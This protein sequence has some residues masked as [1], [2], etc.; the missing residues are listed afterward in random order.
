MMYPRVFSMRHC[1]V[2]RTKTI[3]EQLGALA[4]NAPRNQRT[5]SQMEMHQD[6]VNIQASLQ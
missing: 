6:Q 4:H 2:D 3:V 1:F 5:Q